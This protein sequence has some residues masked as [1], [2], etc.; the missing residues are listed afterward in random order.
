M[1][2]PH[3]AAS[4]FRNGA[5]GEPSTV[6]RYSFANQIHTTWRIAGARSWRKP[7]GARWRAAAR[8]D[9]GTAPFARPGFW[10]SW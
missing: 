6:L 1:S 7:H 9:G 5:A 4:T 3:S 2:M 10:A 8:A